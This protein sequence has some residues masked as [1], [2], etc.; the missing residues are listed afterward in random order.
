MS[1]SLSRRQKTVLFE[2][3]LR[4]ILVD[5]TRCNK[6][7]MD[8][9]KRVLRLVEETRLLFKAQSIAQGVSINASTGN[10]FGNF[11]LHSLFHSK[12]IGY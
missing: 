7:D 12:K 9:L 2:N 5:I 10:F 3:F 4:Y 11:C 8:L 6:D 1:I